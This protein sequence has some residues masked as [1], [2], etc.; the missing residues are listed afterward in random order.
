MGR[1]W[2]AD[3]LEQQKLF[4]KYTFFYFFVP[5]VSRACAASGCARR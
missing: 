2:V 4:L 1:E 3:Q 5:H